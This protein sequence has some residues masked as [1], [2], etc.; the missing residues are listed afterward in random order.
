VSSEEKESVAAKV[1][2]VAGVSKVENQ[3]EVAL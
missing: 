2:H 3:L 1:K